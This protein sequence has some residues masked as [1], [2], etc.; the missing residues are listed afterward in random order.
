MHNR[1]K[2]TGDF[3][4]VA[5]TNGLCVLKFPVTVNKI[6]GSSGYE[7]GNDCTIIHR[8][9]KKPNNNSK[10]TQ[11]PAG[12][13]KEY[14]L[15]KKEITSRIPLY[16]N[17]MT[18]TKRLFFWTITFP[19]GYPDDLCY[20][21]FN[22]WL[23]RLRKEC[24]LKSYLWV[25]ERQRNKTLHYHICISQYLNVQ[26]ANRFM[27][28]SISNQIT[29]LKV[30]INNKDIGRYNGVD[31]AKNRKTKRVVNFAKKSKS[32]ALYLYL[33]KYVSKNNSTSQRYVWHCSREYS[34][35][36]TTVR[37]SFQDAL[38]EGVFEYV[39]LYDKWETKHFIY[40][41]WSKGPPAFITN[42]LTTVNQVILS[43][44]DT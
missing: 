9:A 37:F 31:I 44:I 27:R 11:P 19:E 6:G 3:N 5:S 30:N 13:K 35:L 12:K 16:I 15:N 38:E 32:R 43:I 33:T 29:K 36:S 4:H 40:Y 39:N 25:A 23:T 34:N 42:F 7:L 22:V 1:D 21:A 26:K 8:P 28:A 14:R 17:A 18:G 10:K 20:K 2:I 24:N 41:R